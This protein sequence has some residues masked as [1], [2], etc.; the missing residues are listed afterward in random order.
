ML[1]FEVDISN[2][3]RDMLE[4][5]FSLDSESILEVIGMEAVDTDV[6][7]AFEYERDPISLEDWKP[8]RRAKEQGGKTLQ[9]TGRLKRSIT[10]KIDGDKVYIG[11]NVVY[12]NK[13][14]SGDDGKN[15]PARPFLGV[16]SD[17]LER[18]TPKIKRMLRI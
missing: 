1:I 5:I 17:F 12:A 9:D 2:L 18:V 7:K 8:S 4:F 13:L 10:Y 6:R 16:G 11:T 15:L 14:F 3:E